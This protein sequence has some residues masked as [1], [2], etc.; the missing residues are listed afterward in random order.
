MALMHIS[1]DDAG[2]FEGP[3]KLLEVWF[4]LPPQSTPEARRNI[5]DEDT[6]THGFMDCAKGLRIIPR[7]TSSN[8]MILV[9]DSA[10]MKISTRK[11]NGCTDPSLHVYVL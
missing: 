10:A 6:S 3:E 4:R 2:F 8:K 1:V 5:L 7:Y 9:V 11:N